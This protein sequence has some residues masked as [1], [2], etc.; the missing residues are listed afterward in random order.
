MMDNVAVGAASGG[1]LVWLV[2][3]IKDSS[4]NIEINTEKI[5]SKLGFKL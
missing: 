5:C 4:K 3:Q 2:M 1:I